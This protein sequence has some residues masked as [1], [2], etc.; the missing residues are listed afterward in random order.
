MF[1]N[2]YDGYDVCRFA[3]RVKEGIDA[4]MLGDFISK[5]NDMISFWHLGAEPEGA[6]VRY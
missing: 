5:L 4:E 1:L 3:V 2:C 6:V